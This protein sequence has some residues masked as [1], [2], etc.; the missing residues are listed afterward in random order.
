M[1]ELEIQD[2]GIAAFLRKPF[3]AEEFRKAVEKCLSI[4]IKLMSVD[5][6]ENLEESQEKKGVSS[7]WT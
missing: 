1:E 7:Q 4:D 3:T 5:L 6:H 2:A